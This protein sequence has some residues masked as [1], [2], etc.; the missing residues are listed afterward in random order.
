MTHAGNG[1][2][3]LG[4]LAHP[5]DVDARPP[6]DGYSESPTGCPWGHDTDIVA[7]S[8]RCP[9]CGAR[10]RKGEGKALCEHEAGP[11]DIHLDASEGTVGALW[12]AVHALEDK[13]SGARWRQERPAPPAYLDAMSE[14]A[15]REAGLLREVLEREEPTE[16]D[17][18]NRPRGPLSQQGSGS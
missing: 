14:R 7:R 1:P 10:L 18:G 5:G 9:T 4:R 2:T 8:R 12:S 6:C 15:D 13:A 11:N 3:L 16:S 17:R